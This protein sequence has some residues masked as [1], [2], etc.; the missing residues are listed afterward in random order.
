MNCANEYAALRYLRNCVKRNESLTGRL[1]PEYGLG[2]PLTVWQSLIQT[3]F[4]S[5]P[6]VNEAYC[7]RVSL[8]GL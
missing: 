4:G 5:W 6:S 1:N 2:Q 7:L 8:I 3:K